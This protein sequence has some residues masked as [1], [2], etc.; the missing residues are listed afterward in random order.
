LPRSDALA[1]TV[2]C[3]PLTGEQKHFGTGTSPWSAQAPAK[4]VKHFLCGDE[5][6]A[7]RAWQ[8]HLAG[9]KSPWAG[10][11]LRNIAP[12]ELL[13]WGLHDGQLDGPTR[14]AIES[15]FDTRL[16]RGE[17]GRQAI[18]ATIEAALT[19]GSSGLDERAAVLHLGC[20]YALADL[21]A[22]VPQREWREL[23]GSLIQTARDAAVLDLTAKPLLHQL[24]A[25][26]LPVALA[27]LFAELT[28]CAELKFCGRKALSAGFEELVDGEGLPQRRYLDIQWPLLA[29]WTRARSMSRREQCWDDAAE[30]QYSFAVREMLRLADYRG[31]SLFVDAAAGER[32]QAARF[33]AAVVKLS[34]DK[35]NRRA[36][37]SLGWSD[38]EATRRGANKPLPSA[39]NHSEWAQVAVL[40]PDWKRSSPQLGVAYGER[41]FR[42][43]LAI[44]RARLLCG[45]WPFSVVVD[46]RRS[47]PIDDWEAICWVSDDD[48]DYLELEIGLDEGLKLQRQLCLARKDRFLFVGDAVLGNC[49]RSLCHELSL[50]LGPEVGATL[51]QGVA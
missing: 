3:L 21:A 43:E 26:E 37:A 28:D 47:A 11:R 14:R 35:K 20:A 30:A 10:T 7:W 41:S 4:V 40:R 15:L 23:L 48:V 32:K 42:G 8:K 46:G 51:D 38:R 1:R 34:D 16:S 19:D 9:R 50:P 5:H 24:L 13:Q 36:L 31:G 45:E 27:A 39:A 33:F 25:G 2:G 44:G 22:T 49:A 17:T 12:A 6:R 18:E 29:C